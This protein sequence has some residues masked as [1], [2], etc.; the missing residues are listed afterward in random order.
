VKF[1]QKFW[2]LVSRKDLVFGTLLFVVVIAMGVYETCNKV[3]VTF[4]ETAV[5]ISTSKYS[6]NIPYELVE[7]AELTPLPE[8]GQVIDGTDDMAARTGHWKNSQWGEYYICADL[9][10]PDCVAVRLK[11]GRLFAFSRRSAE[12]TREL[13]EL[14]RSGLALSE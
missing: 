11:D 10:S 8:A 1:W 2:Q 13:Y 6:M 3:T 9:N 5:D 12:V 7:S 14:L 4:S